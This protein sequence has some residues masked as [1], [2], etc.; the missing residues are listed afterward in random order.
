MAY[1]VSI[2]LPL[3][4]KFQN[5]AQPLPR[6]LHSMAFPFSFTISIYL[7][8]TLT[9][10]LLLQIGNGEGVMKRVCRSTRPK[11]ITGFIDSYRK[12]VDRAMDVIYREKF[13]ADDEG[14][15]PDKIYF[16]AQ[17][18]SD[19][20]K[21]DCKTCFIQLD[22]L[23]GGCF[24]YNGGRIYLDGCHLRV[25]NYDFRQQIFSTTDHK[26]CAVSE[27]LPW[28]QA[29]ATRLLIKDIIKRAP[30]DQGYARG[31]K[32]LGV[33]DV[34][35]MATCWKSL[36]DKYCAAC[37][38]KASLSA[39][40]CLPSKEGRVI[41]AGCILHYSDYKFYGHS[42]PLMQGSVLIRIFVICLL[43][44]AVGF[45][46]GKFSYGRLNKHHDLEGLE[47]EFSVLKASLQ[48]KHATLEKAT[49][50]FCAACKLGQGGYGEVFKGT[51]PDGREIA[52]K[53]LSLNFKHRSKDV[54]NEIEIINKA[55]HKNLVRFLG[56][57]LTTESSLLVYEF[58]PNKS[59]DCILFVL[60]DPARKKELDWKKRSAIIV[61]IAEGLEYLHKQLHIIHRDIK[62]SNI[63]L[64][65]RYKPKIADFGL[66][67]F[68]SSEENPVALA[69]AGT[70]GY[71]A[72]EYLAHGRLT[73]KVDVYGFGVLVL[74]IVSGLQNNKFV[75]EDSFSTLVTATWKHYREDT[76]LEIIDR[77]M[78]VEDL[79]EITRAIHVGLLCTQELPLLRP[80]MPMVLRMLTRK[81]EH[82]PTPSK[83]AFF[84]ECASLSASL[85]SASSF[86]RSYSVSQ[87]LAF[88]QSS[89]LPHGS[90]SFGSPFQSFATLSRHD[91]QSFNSLSQSCAPRSRP[92]SQSFSSV[93]EPSLEHNKL[94][95]FR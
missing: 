90:Q 30:A 70:F 14:N 78:D 41:N 35:G 33:G 20:S 58:L 16:M 26:S 69:I 57:C 60:E 34:Y 47:K 25:E 63:L 9:F 37:L 24:P 46:L 38:E 7:T 6:S 27:P 23:F 44:V 75:S 92:S 1:S 80:T 67:S 28:E 77:S 81:T 73:E 8:L 91:S 19:L 84:D 95:F 79:D 74:E 36:A 13:V 82:L 12:I 71:M 29:Q 89:S 2:S 51:L 39:F 94:D 43:A 10:S 56:Y 62:A 55:Q 65:M 32:K 3:C 88:L 11:N 5:F 76:I 50:Y 42:D 52:I 72:P 59:L 45:F 15:E 48:F 83:P 68:C 85:V 31:H 61:G 22:A 87:I 54:I 18:F 66:A 17:C 4:P 64:D 53:R 86:D 21:E 93:L 40:N 49:E